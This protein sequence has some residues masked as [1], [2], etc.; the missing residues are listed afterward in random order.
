MKQIINDPD[1]AGNGVMIT[2][3]AIIGGVGTK[4]AID[5]LE[6]KNPK[7]VT[8]LTPQVWDKGNEA[9]WKANYDA[10]LPPTYSVTMSLPGL[11]D[12]TPAQL[13]SC[14]GPS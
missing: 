4:I 3:P 13:K 1:V 6:K 9:D 11:T 12:F 8:T 10:K 2:N 14:K 7:K 5:A